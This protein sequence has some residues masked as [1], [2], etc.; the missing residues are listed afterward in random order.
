MQLLA[1]PAVFVCASAFIFTSTTV[2]EIYQGYHFEE[3]SS[4]RLLL[5]RDQLNCYLVRMDDVLEQALLVPMTRR[6]V[7]DEV[8]AKINS[9]TDVTDVGKD[10]IKH[11]FHDYLAAAQ[12]ANLGVHVVAYTYVPTVT[13]PPMM[14]STYNA[15]SDAVP[16]VDDV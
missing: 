7:E 15:I 11:D 10:D 14:S 1:L 12:C 4:H 5:I 2:N 13:T 9:N 6:A 16:I 8:I 3:H